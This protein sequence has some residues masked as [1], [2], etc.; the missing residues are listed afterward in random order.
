MDA[1][2]H[3]FVILSKL[4]LKQ[5]SVS[6][7]LEKELKRVKLGIHNL[8]KGKLSPFILSLEILQSSLRQVQDI[9]SNQFTQYHISHIDPLYYYFQGDFIFTKLHSHLFLTLKIPILSFPTQC[10]FIKYTLSQ[11]QKD[12]TFKYY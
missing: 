1:L 11:F 3:E 4:I 5:T 10:Y 12:D 7:Q 6:A 2:E 9:L 8:T